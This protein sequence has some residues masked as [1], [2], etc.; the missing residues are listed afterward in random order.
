M[1]YTLRKYSFLLEAFKNAGYRFVTFQFY[2]EQKGELEGDRFVIFRHD[3]DLKA[4][5][6]L[7]TARIEHELGIKASYY[8]RVI[9]QSN[10]PEIIKAIVAMGHEI[11][12]H[13]EDMAIC[14]GDAEKAS[15]HFKK[16]LVYFRQYY[17]VKTICMH[18][19]PRSKYDGRDLWKQYDY[20]DFDIVG[21][22][23]FDIDYSKVFYLT[24]TGR[25]WD[26]FNVSVRDKIPVFQEQW[27]E[28]G[29]VYHT[30]DDVIRA[31]KAGTFPNQ[32][33][34]TTHPQRWADN[35]VEWITELLLQSIKNV[36]K[37][38]MVAPLFRK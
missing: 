23:Y 5:N 2:C 11:G 14:N 4:E 15:D 18:G 38:V 3:V 10:K 34:M 25:R 9:K 32:L 16:Q 1:D 22:P 31:V 29:L 24:D 19:A 35:K 13:Y 12:Y 20:H 27:V 8:F 7:V 33:M 26:G 17:P 28:K 36:V 37:S 30:T 21:E 6:A